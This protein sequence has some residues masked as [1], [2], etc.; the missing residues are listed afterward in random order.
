MSQTATITIRV[1]DALRD[2]LQQRAEAEGG[3]V[4][5]VLRRAATAYLAPAA[6]PAAAVLGEVQALRA[7]MRAD[8]DK[9]L[10]RLAEFDAADAE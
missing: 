2:A 3:T 6:D 4:A 5:D 8:V 10:A 9:L 7:D 1:T